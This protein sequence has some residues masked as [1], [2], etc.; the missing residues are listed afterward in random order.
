MITTPEAQLRGIIYADNAKDRSSAVIQEM[1]IC[2]RCLEVINIASDK[3]DVRYFDLQI[4][5]KAYK[6]A[7]PICPSCGEFVEARY[8]L[9]N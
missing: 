1:P 6:L 2:P 7:E 8:H 3:V 5:G 9:V 4:G